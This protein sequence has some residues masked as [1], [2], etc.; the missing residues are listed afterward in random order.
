MLL[1]PCSPQQG[2]QPGHCRTSRSKFPITCCMQCYLKSSGNNLHER[3][4]MAVAVPGSIVSSSVYSS[5]D[6][7]AT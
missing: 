3:G 6:N 5:L 4:Q 7:C 1:L 2:G